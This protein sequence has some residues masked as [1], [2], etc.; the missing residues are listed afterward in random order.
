MAKLIL[1]SYRVNE[2]VMENKAAPETKIQLEF[3]YGYQVAHKGGNACVGEITLNI[4]DKNNPGQFNIKAVLLGYFSI[5]GEIS[6]EE[7]HVQ[8]F[9]DL[10]PYMRSF[11]STITT[12]SGMMP[13]IP[14]TFNI[15]DHPV[16]RMDKNDK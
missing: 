7:I 1:R 16:L 8:S 6:K 12:N 13:I 3:K 4:A 15:E 2:I 14:P 11:I 9:K 10:F 5:E